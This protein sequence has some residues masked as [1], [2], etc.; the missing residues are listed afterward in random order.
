[1]LLISNI[2]LRQGSPR[3]LLPEPATQWSLNP[4]DFQK[5]TE[6]KVLLVHVSITM[7]T[8]NRDKLSISYEYL[9]GNLVWHKDSRLLAVCS[10]RFHMREQ[11]LCGDFVSE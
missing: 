3:V 2:V 5:T 4:F 9:T 11:V 1:M 10:A 8:S 6:E 7:P